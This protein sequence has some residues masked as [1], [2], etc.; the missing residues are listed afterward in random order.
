MAAPAGATIHPMP[1][2]RKPTLPSRSLNRTPVTVA[3]PDPGR[4]DFGTRQ[5]VCHLAFGSPGRLSGSPGAGPEPGRGHDGRA[6]IGL[7][8]GRPFR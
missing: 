1:C 2:N 4:G 6:R 3:A 5:D 7:I 8:P